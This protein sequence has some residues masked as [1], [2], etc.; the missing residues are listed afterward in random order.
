MS[1][2]EIERIR[3]DIE[4]IREAAGL[5]LPFGWEEVWLSVA[6]VPC[7]LVLSAVGAWAPLGS[8]RLGLLPA[9]GVVLASG[10]LRYRYRKSS[11]RSPVRRKEYD[12][13]LAAGLFYGLIAGGFLAWARR[14]GE[15]TLLTGGL[16]V[17]MAG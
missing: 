7:G 12:L 1:E 10:V 16:A 17:T 8:A 6:L 14:L 4:V 9:L 13:G 3:R 11:G 5:E 2:A 15:Q